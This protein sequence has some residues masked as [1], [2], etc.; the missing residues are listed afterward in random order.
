MA[1]TERAEGWCATEHVTI[2]ARHD[3]LFA[4]GDASGPQVLATGV[5][6]DSLD[7]LLAGGA[8]LEWGRVWTSEAS[9]PEAI[10]IRVVGLWDGHRV[11][12]TL[13]FLIKEHG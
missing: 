10:R 5:L 12:D 13:L 3:T 11:S 7:Y 1:W 8:T 9:A 2:A 4:S 6:A